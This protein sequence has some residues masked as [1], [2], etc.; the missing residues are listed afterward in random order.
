MFNHLPTPLPVLIVVARGHLLYSQAR[1]APGRLADLLDVGSGPLH[2]PAA[3]LSL[4]VPAAHPKAR[5]CVRDRRGARIRRTR[6]R[7]LDPVDML[8]ETV[9]SGLSVTDILMGATP[10]M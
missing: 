2:L 6:A 5:R 1:H 3:R 8:T 10:S 4:Q 7:V 9:V